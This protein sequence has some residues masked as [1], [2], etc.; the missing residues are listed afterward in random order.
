MTEVT[1]N[2]LEALT[3]KYP[4][5]TYSVE[6]QQAEQQ[7]SLSALGTGFALA[8]LLIYALLAIPF[9]SYVQPLI[10]MLAIPFSFI[11][12]VAGPP[13]PGVWAEFDQS[14]R[15]RGPGRCGGQ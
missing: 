2:E 4:G 5:L 3:K 10:V 15:Y 6:G 1:A 7:E 11:G 12:A 13:A 14:V 8:M 9:R